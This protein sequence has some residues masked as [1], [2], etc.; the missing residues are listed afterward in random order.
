MKKQE[1]KL[2]QEKERALIKLK[3]EKL[4]SEIHFKSMQLANT[5]YSMIK[6]NEMLLEIKKLLG[7]SKR[8]IDPADWN[9][10][11][12]V[13]SLLDRNITNEDD[14]K[15]FESN[16]EQ[17]HEE[18]LQRIKKDISGS[19][20]GRP[21]IMRLYPDEPILKKDC[22]LAWNFHRGVENHRYRL[23]RKMDLDRDVN[24][25]SLYHG[26]LIPFFF[27]EVNHCFKLKRDSFFR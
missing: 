19:Y 8:N 5:T 13:L 10:F 22:T 25:T 9:H 15:V 17:A 2:G 4:E 11:K 26:I 20:P 3:N 24:L 6:K 7:R 16:F 23:R 27:S 14:W 18:F 1:I 12:D 21:E